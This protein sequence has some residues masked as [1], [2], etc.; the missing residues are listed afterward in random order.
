MYR[1]ELQF[2]QSAC[3]MMLYISMKVHENIFNSFQVIRAHT[4]WQLSNFKG[5]DFK[6]LLIRVMVL[7]V[8]MSSNS[9]DTILWQTDNQHKKQ[10]L[11]T[12]RGRKLGQESNLLVPDTPS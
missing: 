11:H 12:F 5:E 3:L 9:A 6:N 2:L 1:Q 7:V 8:C 10:G 4:K